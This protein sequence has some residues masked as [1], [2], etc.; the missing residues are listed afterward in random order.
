MT[1]PDPHATAV[2]V[3]TLNEVSARVVAAAMATVYTAKTVA[4]ISPASI[5]LSALIVR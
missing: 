2:Q 3:W 1:V 4:V 5:D